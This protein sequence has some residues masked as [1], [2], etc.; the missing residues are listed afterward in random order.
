MET[1]K[2]VKPL[3]KVPKLEAIDHM[4]DSDDMNLM[5]RILENLEDIDPEE[6]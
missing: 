6:E 4:N 5:S 2:K 1:K 3:T